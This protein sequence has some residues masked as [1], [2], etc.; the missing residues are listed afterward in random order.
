MDTT[1]QL[2]G[3]ILFLQMLYVFNRDRKPYFFGL[4][5]KSIVLRNQF[6]KG[7]LI[8]LYIFLA[9]AA[10]GKLAQDLFYLR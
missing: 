1:Y 6:T 7:M 9:I 8:S 3:V 5:P 10:F 2:I 4:T